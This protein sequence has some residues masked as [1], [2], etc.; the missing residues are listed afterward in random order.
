MITLQKSKKNEA[1]IARKMLFHFVLLFVVTGIVGIVG[2]LFVQS[3]KTTAL[4]VV[5]VFLSLLIML[6]VLVFAI[7]RT[8]K[9]VKKRIDEFI[10]K[11]YMV[12][13]HFGRHS[14]PGARDGRQHEMDLHE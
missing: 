6:A 7:I 13:I 5:W 1:N 9:I 11:K 10:E 3:A 4:K 8:K 12:R 14:V 2:F